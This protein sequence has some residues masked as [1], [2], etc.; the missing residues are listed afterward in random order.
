MLLSSVN[1]HVDPLAV[2]I[3]RASDTATVTLND[4]RGLVKNVDGKIDDLSGKIN[5]AIGEASKTLK[6]ADEAL[7]AISA[8]LEDGLPLRFEVSNALEELAEPL[9][10]SESWH[11]T[12][13]DTRTPCCAAE[14]NQE[15]ND[16]F[17]RN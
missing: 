16:A 6:G 3:K 1:S 14:R 11:T 10:P 2:S 17:N 9:N 5:D 15:A 13:N 4:T 8:T 7:G 12:W